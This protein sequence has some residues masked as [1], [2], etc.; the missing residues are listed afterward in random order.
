MYTWLCRLECKKIVLLKCDTVMQSLF[1]V[2]SDSELM[3]VYL[4]CFN[5]QNTALICT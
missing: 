2:F 3:S 1:N 4:S 5:N